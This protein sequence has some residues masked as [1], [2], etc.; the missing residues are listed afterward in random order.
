MIS[1]VLTPE[2][3]E[4]IQSI[5]RQRRAPLWNLGRDFHA[6]RVQESSDIEGPP[7]NGQPSLPGFTTMNYWESEA[8]PP[9][10]LRNLQL[11][12]L[13]E[14]QVRNAA[15]ALAVMHR[16]RDAGWS[17]SDKALRSGLS[18]ARCPARIELIA[19]EPAVIID[20]AHNLASIEAL[21]Q[22]L[23]DHFW[24]R[25]RLLIFAAS[26]DKDY[27]G[28]LRAV[29]PHFHRVIL[30]SYRNN[31]RGVPP[32]ELRRVLGERPDPMTAWPEYIEVMMDPVCSWHAARE[33]ATP[34]D[35]ICI[36]GSFFLAA[37]IRPLLQETTEL[38]RPTP[39]DP[40]SCQRAGA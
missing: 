29:A 40:Q 36:A 31:P 19:K 9:H 39:C 21:L 27:A 26:Q 15:V 33:W 16:L 10:R 13:G 1:G 18:L 24:A 30:T 8:D 38:A 3:R 35:L 22:V 2:P 32:V 6:E 23:K 11:G 7:N 17:I 34:N 25:R 28:M 20:A 37:E 4:V 14:H 5:A 12:L